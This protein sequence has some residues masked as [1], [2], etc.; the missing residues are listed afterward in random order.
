MTKNKVS[1]RDDRIRKL[2]EL[3]E[4]GI[5]PYPA[6]VKKLSTIRDI[7]TYHHILELANKEIFITGRLKSIRSH[8]NLTFANLED[9]S[10]ESVNH[11][12]DHPEIVER[13]T[14]LHEEWARDV[15][16]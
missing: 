14:K 2:N 3:R 12:A 9:E 16:K 15:F 7:V 5:D 13:L 4:K 11:A 8:G 6:K 10:P 1:E